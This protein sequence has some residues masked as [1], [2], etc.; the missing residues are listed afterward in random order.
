MRAHGLAD[1][2]ADLGHLQT[3]LRRNKWYPDCLTHSCEHCCHFARGGAR[4]GRAITKLKESVWYSWRL[5]RANRC[6]PCNS[7]RTANTVA[8][9]RIVNRFQDR[10]SNNRIGNLIQQDRRSVECSM[11]NSMSKLW[12]QSVHV[13]MRHIE[14]HQQVQTTAWAATCANVS[15]RVH[16]F[17]CIQA[18]IA[19]S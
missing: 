6:K 15:Q 13:L 10:N 14:A 3:T 9:A 1:T 11:K 8:T 2:W 4:R 19:I 18:A 5:L 16:Q 7:V 17:I 12:Y